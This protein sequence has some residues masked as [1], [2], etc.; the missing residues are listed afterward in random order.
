MAFGEAAGAQRW[1][2]VQGQLL[3]ARRW[4]DEVVVYNDLSGDTHLLDASAMDL[5][6]ALQAD[7]T[8]TGVAFAAPP[9]WDAGAF[10]DLLDTLASHHLIESAAC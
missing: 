1:R 10:D 6:L 2:L 5:L 7:A 9:D 8:P 4:G 3:L